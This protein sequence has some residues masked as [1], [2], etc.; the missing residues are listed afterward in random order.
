MQSLHNESFEN[1]QGNRGYNIIIEYIIN[2]LRGIERE[3]TNRAAKE[4]EIDEKTEDWTK[5]FKKLGYYKS[6]DKIIGL[7]GINKDRRDW[8]WIGQVL[9]HS[10]FNSVH[11]SWYRSK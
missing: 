3:N 10:V 4:K 2:Q 1:F 5:E 8:G 11:I 6:E 7:N 9:L